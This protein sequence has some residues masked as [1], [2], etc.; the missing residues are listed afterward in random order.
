MA[1]FYVTI[2]RNLK[3]FNAL[4]LKQIFWKTKTFKK[5]EY[6]LLVESNKM[7]NAIFPYKTALSEAKEE[8]K[9]DL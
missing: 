4:T 1:S 7:E 5:P 2:S 6:C 3:V 9:I 8:Y